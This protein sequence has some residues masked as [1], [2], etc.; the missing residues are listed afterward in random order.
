MPARP[1]ARLRLA[2]RALGSARGRRWTRR[3]RIAVQVG[4]L[5]LVAYQLTQ[6][7]WA[8]VAAALPSR[9]LFYGLLVAYYVVLPISEGF[10]YRPVWGTP[11]VRTVLA[12]ARKRLYNDDVLGYSGEATLYLWAT[13]EGV[14]PS[15]AFRT[16]RDNNL[17]SG[18]VSMVATVALAA[19]AVSSGVLDLDGRAGVWAPVGA[20]AGV[21]GLVGVLAV[22]LRQKLFSLSAR[23]TAR[24]AALHSA[25]FVTTS[26]L[27]ITMWSVAVPSVG[28]DTWVA[29]LAVQ[30]VL[31][32][33]PFVPG[34]DLLFVGVGT[35]LAETLEVAQ[36]AV[37]GTLLITA[38]GVKILNVA[39][40]GL[41]SAVL[42][43]AEV[44]P[45]RPE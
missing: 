16:V 7:G 35:G 30:Q 22:L 43:K 28:V 19:L 44:V 21:L 45:P 18:A 41:A 33:L 1:R 20:V 14:G 24:I 12:C 9:P 2:R 17:L 23:Q 31:N 8:R 29:L 13:R 11:W 40:F 32:R 5:A 37:A 38:V 34:K 6:V 42:P 36:A 10:I 4:I 15:D 39:A 26:T 3:L 27:L 25:R